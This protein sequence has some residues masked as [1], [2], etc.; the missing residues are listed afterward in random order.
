[1][2]NLNFISTPPSSPKTIALHRDLMRFTKS[3]DF[4]L[5]LD[6]KLVDFIIFSIKISQFVE[7][8][9]PEVPQN[10]LIMSRY[11][12][13][14][15][16][17]LTNLENLDRVKSWSKNLSF[18]NLHRDKNKSCLNSWENLARFQKPLL[19]RSRCLDLDLNWSRLLKPPGLSRSHLMR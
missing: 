7:I 12:N 16:K 2:R 1:L 15:Q 18:K 8:F 11:V 19:I 14:S 13:K 9:K 4:F 6:C 10:V 5:H 17:V 3:L